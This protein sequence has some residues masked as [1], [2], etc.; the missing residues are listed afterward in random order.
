MKEYLVWYL[1][2]PYEWVAVIRNPDAKQRPAL[3]R[4]I[5]SWQGYASSS[6][7]AIQQAKTA[8]KESP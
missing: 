7:N 3:T 6:E 5:H 2:N 1:D 8:Y 4:L